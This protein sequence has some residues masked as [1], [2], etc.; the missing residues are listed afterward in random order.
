M[1]R[2]HSAFA[3]TNR[4]RGSV[5][6]FVLINNQREKHLCEM[7]ELQILVNFVRQQLSQ[8]VL[9][10]RAAQNAVCQLHRKRPQEA[11]AA[12]R[13]RGKVLDIWC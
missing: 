11:A 4:Q 10:P 8:A 9:Q 5:A 6:I 12:G 3:L 7:Q 13:G 2:H 1:G